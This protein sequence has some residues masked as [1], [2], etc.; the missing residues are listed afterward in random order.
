[1][2]SQ[3]IS[4]TVSNQTSEIVPE[5]NTSEKEEQHNPISND[6]IETAALQKLRVIQKKHQ[7][8][9][10]K[11][12]N[13]VTIHYDRI[14]KLQRQRDDA[15]QMVDKMKREMKLMTIGPGKNGNVVQRGTQYLVEY[16]NKMMKNK[17]IQKLSTIQQQHESLGKKMVAMIAI[18]NNRVQE[19]EHQ[20]VTAEQNIV[21]VQSELMEIK[22]KNTELQ[23]L[24]DSE[25]ILNC[26]LRT[27]RDT[28]QSKVADLSAMNEQMRLDSEEQR[29]V[30]ILSQTKCEGMK[31]QHD[32][33][34]QKI[35]NLKEKSRKEI[36]EF[37]R[38]LQTKDALMSDAQRNK[39]KEM[40]LIS[41]ELHIKLSSL[42]KERDDLAASL[43]EC[44]DKHRDKVNMLE[45]KME[46]LRSTNQHLQRQKEILID[47][48]DDLRSK[49]QESVVDEQRE[50]TI[51]VMTQTSSL[52]EDHT[53]IYTPSKPS[54]H[55]SA[56]YNPIIGSWQV[57][58][59]NES[60]FVAIDAILTLNISTFSIAMSQM[61]HPKQR[62][63]N[64]K[65]C[66][67]K[68]LYLGKRDCFAGIYTGTQS[69]LHGKTRD[70]GYFSIQSVNGKCN[71]F[72]AHSATSRSDIL[73]AMINMMKQNG[74]IPMEGTSKAL[75]R[76]HSFDGS[77]GKVHAITFTGSTSIVLG[78]HRL[79]KPQVVR[80]TGN[81][82]TVR[83][84]ETTKR[85]MSEQR[86][87][88]K[89][90]EKPQELL[91]DV[92]ACD[93]SEKRIA[94]I[95]KDHV[96]VDLDQIISDIFKG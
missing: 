20:R 44:K 17:A 34:Q 65:W 11:V 55:P 51:D 12:R 42:D 88:C 1:M 38:L 85:T 37:R 75:R 28:I 15:I 48:L 18:H 82:K 39:T 57:M 76:I 59:Y 80:T 83:L 14:Q 69:K 72:R 49:Y 77:K 4:F 35:S 50:K 41:S 63:V 3:S 10:R 30:A 27:E 13:L 24:L 91:D 7:T 26:T 43:K 2:E 94:P 36:A 60:C 74:Q 71:D 90:L 47:T 62:A 8:L 84:E 46:N 32:I 86:E 73:S 67:T 9:G 31:V 61:S 70:Y 79:S 56:E 21:K 68:R 52:D 40:D 25:R 5:R 54:C 53:V 22:E 33:L 78:A 95:M 16:D 93:M 23:D 29:R 92:E 58:R 89:A 45:Q 19:I 64:L 96:S 6:I 66:E 81:D 87:E